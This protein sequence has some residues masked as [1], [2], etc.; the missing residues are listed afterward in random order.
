MK[1]V[2][3]RD[4]LD[5]FTRIAIIGIGLSLPVWLYLAELRPRFVL[6]RTEKDL[7][8][9][10]AACDQAL[11]SAEATEETRAQLDPAQAARLDLSLEIGRLPCKSYSVLTEQLLSEGVSRHAL[12]ALNLS[13][14]SDPAYPDLR[15]VLADADQLDAQLRVTSRLFDLA[16]LPLK[17]Y[18][19]NAKFRLGERLFFDP[20]LSGQGDRTCA[21][22]HVLVSAT[23]DGAALE[24]HLDVSPEW[25]PGVPARNVPDLWNRDHNDVST[26]L[27]DGRVQALAA[28]NEGGLVSP[29]PLPTTG[30]ENLMALQSI[31]PIIIPAEMLG[32]PGAGNV[33]A[34]KSLGAPLPE[35]VLTRL[36]TRLYEDDE[37][38]KDTETY[39]RLFRKSYGV[40]AA[41]EVR[42]AH[43]GNALAHYIEIAFQSRET[44]W[45]RY[46]V[47]DLSALTADQK[48]GAVLFY[49][50][51][52]CAVCHVGDVFSD[53]GFH[54]IGVPDM[55]EEK[56]LGRFYATGLAEDRFLFRTPP[57][58]NVT[59]TAPY[60]HNGQG[61]TL[62]EA[63]QQHL[64]PYQFARAYAEGGEHLMGSTEID[65]ISPILA[66]R[67]MITD[68]QIE[69]LIAFLKSLEDRRADA[70]SP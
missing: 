23:A 64:N 37:R 4:V 42:P 30:F 14:T 8:A 15:A 55:R 3:P 26:M 11:R 48:R 12:A 35:A 63:I 61:K 21:T 2:R 54:S 51:G 13:A 5:L 7:R 66:P 20:L 59:L 36:A 32:E 68:A 70:L 38:G 53:F 60:F 49:G 45:D 56:D 28:A 22:C 58:R 9:L 6:H 69:L 41:E 40:G 46:L 62:S 57:L 1:R 50:V 43:L 52:K 24:T 18:L 33:L 19:R 29:E 27:W 16:P 47:G 65:A 31:R 39:Q 34:P 17:E 67:S 10:A 44:P 25:L